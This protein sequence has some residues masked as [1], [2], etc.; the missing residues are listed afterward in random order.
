M[1][2]LIQQSL[3]KIAFYFYKAI[4]ASDEAKRWLE[5]GRGLSL[6]SRVKR[7]L[8]YKSIACLYRSARVDDQ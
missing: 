1:Q 4:D 3:E 5:L 2:M 7:Y 8:D 6:W